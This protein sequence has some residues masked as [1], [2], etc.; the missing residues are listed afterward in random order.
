V[1]GAAPGLAAQRARER[2]QEAK[3]KWGLANLR[4]GY[5]LPLDKARE[6]GLY[7]S[8]GRGKTSAG[9]EEPA[10]FAWMART[11]SSR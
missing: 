1:P 8:T 5:G 10:L 3:D 6:W 11:Q 4:V 2:A 9:I 7:V